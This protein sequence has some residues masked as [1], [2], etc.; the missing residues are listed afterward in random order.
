MPEKTKL[1]EK[2]QQCAEA[3]RAMK[4]AIAEYKAGQPEGSEVSAQEW[5]EKMSEKLRKSKEDHSKLSNELLEIEKQEKADIEIA[6]IQEYAGQHE[7]FYTEPINRQPRDPEEAGVNRKQG[8]LEREAHSLSR[9][10]RTVAERNTVTAMRGD[11]RT[12]K[13]L[14]LTDEQNEL[15]KRY[16]LSS[17]RWSQEDTRVRA[18]REECYRTIPSE[19]FALLT[20]SGE[21]GGFLVPEDFQAEVVRDLAGFSVFRAVAR[22]IRTSKDVAVYPTI[23]APTAANAKKGYPSRFAGSWKSQGSMAGGGTALTTQDQPK[24]GQAR[25]PIFRWEPDAIELSIETLE[26]PDA[27]VEQILA[28]IIAETKGIDENVAFTEGN[29]QSAPNGITNYALTSVNSGAAAALK[30][31]GLLTLTGTLPAQYRQ[32][33]VMMMNSLTYV[34]AL[35]L[36]TSTGGTSLVFQQ[37]MAENING[38]QFGRLMG[39]RVAFNEIMPSE[40]SNLY[41]IIFG[42]F[43]YYIIADRMELR[44]QRLVERA[45]PNVAF[46]PI[47]RTGGDLVRQNAFVRQKCS[48]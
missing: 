43:R 10:A 38:Q 34:S 22:V 12:Y 11:A 31:S 21:T 35:G 18:L 4:E 2:R 14:A 33:A 45:A 24:Y 36:E 15:Y 27:N 1:E 20:S 26:D 42:D 41:P 30:F 32:N 7:R 29:G 23:V 8:Y 17:V 37:A 25:I 48:T 9:S 19:T 13:K 28:E 40:G 47:A 39:Y 44:I 46:L 6:E 16:F 3:F 5:S